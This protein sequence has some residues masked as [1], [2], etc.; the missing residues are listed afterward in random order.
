MEYIFKF[1]NHNRWINAGRAIHCCQ[2]LR[3]LRNT[4]KEF[5]SKGARGLIKYFTY[6]LFKYKDPLI[7]T[8]LRP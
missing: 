3:T 5:S 1:I 6:K 2:M 8:F 4:G 7:D